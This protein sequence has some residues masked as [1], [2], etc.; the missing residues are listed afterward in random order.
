I[1]I[2]LWLR[3]TRRAALWWGMLFHFMIETTSQVELFT[4]VTLVAYGFFATMDDR[5]RTFAFDASV[6]RGRILGR[7]VRAFDWLSRFEVVGWKEDDVG[8]AHL[9]VVTNRDGTKSTGFSAVIAIAEALPILFPL[10]A[11][12]ALVGTFLTKEKAS[13]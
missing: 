11:P 8:G 12:L 5:A 10:W 3:R 1:A 4:W 7:L 6:P 13:T 2:G 9:V